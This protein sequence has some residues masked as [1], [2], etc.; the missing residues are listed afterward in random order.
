F[1]FRSR[2]GKW[3]LQFEPNKDFM[4]GAACA[5]TLDNLL[6]YV[7]AFV[8]VE[9]A[10]LSC[11]VRQRAFTD[12]FPNLGNPAKNAEGFECLSTDFLGSSQ[13]QLIPDRVDFV[14]RYQQF[15]I[16]NARII[17]AHNHHLTAVQAYLCK[18]QRL[19]T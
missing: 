11:L 4:D 3:I 15:I 10:F 18:R 7:T 8:E 1:N 5:D 6:P 14:C 9:S 2:G 17:T 13:D 19:V 12:I 16:W